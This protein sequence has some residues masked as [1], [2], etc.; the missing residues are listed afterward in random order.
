MSN[1]FNENLS[2][3]LTSCKESALKELT[4][5]NSD[6]KQLSSNATELSIRMK[7]EIP[8]E[9][10]ALLEDFL[11]NFHVRIGMEINCI[12]LQG[13]KD[14]INLYKRFDSSFT[15]S[16]DFEKLFVEQY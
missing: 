4:E 6:Y 9:H 13:F 8:C 7:K 5:N 1:N 15:Q 10:Q 3:F 12:Y 16:Q 2:M 14:C 11:E